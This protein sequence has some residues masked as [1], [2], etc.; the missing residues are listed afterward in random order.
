[1]ARELR[2]LHFNDVYNIEGGN[3]EPVGGAARFA[4][5]VL[6]LIDEAESPPLVLFSGDCFNPSLMSTMTL[7]KQMPPILNKMNVAVACVGNH[8][9]D[10]GIDNFKALVQ[11]CKFPWL[12]ANVLDKQSGEP[13]GG[14]GRSVM[15][16]H[17]GI[18]IG[19]MGLVEQDWIECLSTVEPEDVEFLDPVEEG[20]RLAKELRAQGADLV[21]ALTHMRVPNDVKLA[22]GVAEIDALLGGHDHHVQIEV[23]QPHNNLLCKSGTDF[24]NLTALT[25]TLPPPATAN[26]N[27]NH[28]SQQPK[29][30]KP[31]FKWQSYEITSDVT[32]DEEIAKIVAEYS[33]LLGSRMDEIL[34]RTLTPLD[35]RFSTVRTRESN[36]C[37]FLCDAFRRACSADVVILN[38]GTFRCVWVVYLRVVFI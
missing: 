26:G 1:M 5:K 15:I 14:V 19:I 24:R 6:S 37:N 27:S 25:V 12:M 33:E 4:S 7:G 18:K 3:Q 11:Q 30:Q 36:L 23:L 32:E 20:R 22:E 2:I 8:D 35:G 28:R 13:L 38:S 9:F 17:Q 29:P 16:D 21:I 34:T 10:Y 31:K